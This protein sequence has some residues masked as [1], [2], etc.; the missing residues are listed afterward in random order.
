MR[1]GCHIDNGAWFWA[2]EIEKKKEKDTAKKLAEDGSTSSMSMDVNLYVTRKTVAQ[3]LMDV[4]LLTANAAQ[5]KHLLC[6]PDDHEYFIAAVFFISLSLTL[7][8]I[9]GVILIV[10]GRWN[11]N[12][13]KEQNRAEKFNN[14]IILLAFLVIVVNVL[15]SAFGLKGPI[16]FE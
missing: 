2:S 12:V 13:S 1:Y 7:Q 6:H 5:L 8:V 15:I 11:V 14:L 4:A 3:G 9:V 16:F 10:I